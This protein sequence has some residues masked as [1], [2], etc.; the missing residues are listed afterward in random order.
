MAFSSI[1]VLLNSLVFRRYNPEEE[2]K[3]LAFIRR[4][5]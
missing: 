2:Y 1:S 4:N 5:L 3:L